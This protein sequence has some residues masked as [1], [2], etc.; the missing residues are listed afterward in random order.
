MATNIVQ[1]LSYSGLVNPSD[2][3]PT[4][5][6]LKAN[7]SENAIYC[8][9]GFGPTLGVGRDLYI[10]S[11]SDANSDS[12]SKYLNSSFDCPPHVTPSTFLSGSNNFTVNEMEVFVYQE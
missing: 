3:G 2:A 6:P 11:E 5:L 10:S 1:S 8:D 12:Y 4:K 7:S 9:G